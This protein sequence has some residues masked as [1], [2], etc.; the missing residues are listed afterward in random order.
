MLRTTLLIVLAL[1]F[2]VKA[3]TIRAEDLGSIGSHFLSEYNA[4][5]ILPFAPVSTFGKKQVGALFTELRFK[6]V[7]EHL[8]LEYDRALSCIESVKTFETGGSTT[9]ISFLIDVTD[10][11]RNRLEVAQTFGLPEP[12]ANSISELRLNFAN[13]EVIAP[14]K[15]DIFE[16][17]LATSWSD[18]RYCRPY[19]FCGPERTYVVVGVVQAKVTSE[20]YFH[21]NTSVSQAGAAA[22]KIAAVL[23]FGEPN[24]PAQFSSTDRKPPV[25]IGTGG[26]S[27]AV[28]F[29]LDYWRR[30]MPRSDFSCR[31]VN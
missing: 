25:R 14:H 5:L 23:G 7:G 11:A 9:N 17:I 12:L 4:R 19:V 6:R 24:I 16:S 13:I 21:A 29:D 1:L 10:S 30:L 27:V 18:T 26:N 15:S 3:S 22:S 2:N 8:A 28:A 31:S 20:I